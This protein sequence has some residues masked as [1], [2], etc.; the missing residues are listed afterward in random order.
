MNKELLKGLLI[1]VVA[2]CAIGAVFVVV[3]GSGPN[4]AGCIA[5]AIKNGVDFAKIE[6]VCNLK[7]RG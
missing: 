6:K 2:V 7:P 4:S 1:I 3:S 5:R